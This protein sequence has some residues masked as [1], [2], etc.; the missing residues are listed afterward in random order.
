VVHT[1]PQISPVFY[2]QQ[3]AKNRR[4]AVFC[5][6]TCHLALGHASALYYFFRRADFRRVVFFAAFLA[7]L[8]LRFAVF[9]AAF[10][11]G[12]RFAAFRA[13]F[14]AMLNGLFEVS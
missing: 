5:N 4:M 12:F 2:E 11:A 8:R 7:V 1:I 6:N 3:S 9:R 10:L 13:F 14:A